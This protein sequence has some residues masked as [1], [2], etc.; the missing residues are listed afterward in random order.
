MTALEAYNARIVVY[1]VGVAE[2]AYQDD[3]QYRP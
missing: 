1:T 2:P 3:R